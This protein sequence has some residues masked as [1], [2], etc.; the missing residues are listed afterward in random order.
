MMELNERGNLEFEGL[1]FKPYPYDLSP[2]IEQLEAIARIA[3]LHFNQMLYSLSAN[4]EPSDVVGYNAE[5]GQFLVHLHKF[6]GHPEHCEY[7][8]VTQQEVWREYENIKASERLK[9]KW[10][11][12]KD[13]KR[14]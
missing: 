11:E 5:A 10:V 13:N 2:S 3:G 8:R 7:I 1:E 14:P 9:N 6:I 12:H 4:G